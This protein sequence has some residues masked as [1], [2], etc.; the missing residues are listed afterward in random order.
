[1]M[2]APCNT[3]SPAITQNSQRTAVTMPATVR[4]VP[5]IHISAVAC[6]GVSTPIYSQGAIFPQHFS[7]TPT[8]KRTIRIDT[9]LLAEAESD[10]PKKKRQDAAEELRQVVATVGKPSGTAATA[11]DR[12]DRNI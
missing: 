11:S 12:A 7:N 6:G 3:S 2:E 4:D 5:G 1:M 9:K 8:E 10:D